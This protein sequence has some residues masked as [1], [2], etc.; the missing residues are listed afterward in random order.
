MEITANDYFFQV[1]K[2]SSFHVIVST[3]CQA[4]ADAVF[5]QR[6]QSLEGRY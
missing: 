6:R 5:R 4:S 1:I 2:V 3:S